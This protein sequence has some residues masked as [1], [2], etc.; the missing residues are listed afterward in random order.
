MGPELDPLLC[1]C[2]Y[3]VASQ[4]G[5]GHSGQQSPSQ[6]VGVL[7]TAVRRASGVPRSRTDGHM[8][9]ADPK[10]LGTTDA[11]DA[12]VEVRDFAPL[13]SFGSLRQ[14]RSSTGAASE[15][16]PEDATTSLLFAENTATLDQY[17]DTD[18][19]DY[20]RRRRTDEREETNEWTEEGINY[21]DENVSIVTGPKPAPGRTRRGR[22]LF[23]NSYELPD[24][25]VAQEGTRE[26]FQA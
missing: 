23:R 1:Y 18:E 26:C 20:G 12:S 22:G 25:N 13:V 5:G 10:R 14:L 15:Q 3:R 8:W 2:V 9:S 6:R 19:T 24:P 11:F 17:G 7:A 4:R 16:W 21:R